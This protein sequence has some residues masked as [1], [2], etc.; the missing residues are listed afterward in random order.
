MSEANQK[1]VDPFDMAT[2]FIGLGENDNAFKW[3]DKAF[4][5]RSIHLTN[6]L[7][8][9]PRLDSIRLDQRYTA[10]LKKIGLGK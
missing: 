4:E 2:I 5:E 8:M 7:K 1:Y 9:D 6:N 10:L 3:L